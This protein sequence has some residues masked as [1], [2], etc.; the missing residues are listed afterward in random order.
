MQSSSTMIRWIRNLGRISE[1]IKV[2]FQMVTERN[3]AIWWFTCSE[4]YFQRVGT[5]NNWKSTSPSMS[6]NSGNRQKVIAR[7][8]EF[9]GLV[10]V[11]A[12]MRAWVC[13]CVCKLDYIVHSSCL[14][15]KKTLFSIKNLLFIESDRSIYSFKR[16]KYVCHNNIQP[17]S[18]CTPASIHLTL[19]YWKSV[20]YTHIKHCLHNAKG[21]L[22]EHPLSYGDD[23]SMSCFP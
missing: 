3:Y 5:D 9:S 18:F 22:G 14:E 23:T 4:S 17:I 7:W 20:E 10:C 6:F 8:T 11:C 12:C 21:L 16:T 1:S 15:H 19:R 13:A 2:S